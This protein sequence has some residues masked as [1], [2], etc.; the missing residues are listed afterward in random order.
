[1]LL[2]RK[3]Y[4]LVFK[5]LLA[6]LNIRQA[7]L[8]LS[9]VCF[10]ALTI[11]WRHWRVLKRAR[12][13]VPNAQVCILSMNIHKSVHSEYEPRSVRALLAA[14]LHS[15]QRWQSRLATTELCSRERLRSQ[16]VEREPTVDLPTALS[17]S[18]PGTFPWARRRNRVLCV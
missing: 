10:M 9:R 4:L 18:C 2:Y 7:Q 13:L 6:N 3:I 12:F 8:N 17:A 11:R 16:A 1:M 5:I 14:R 15:Y